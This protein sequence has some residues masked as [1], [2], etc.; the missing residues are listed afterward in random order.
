MY[1]EIIIIKQLSC[2]PLSFKAVSYVILLVSFLNVDFRRVAWSLIIF[3]LLD[4]L[5]TLRIFK[6]TVFCSVSQDYPWPIHSQP[7]HSYMWLAG[8]HTGMYIH[9]MKKIVLDILHNSSGFPVSRDGL[10][11]ANTSV[12]KISSKKQGLQLWSVFQLFQ[13]SFI[14]FH[15]L[16]KWSVINPLQPTYNGIIPYHV[17]LSVIYEYCMTGFDHWNLEQA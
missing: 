2:A 4:F 13:E 15:F 17:P 7:I 14:H 1:L 3:Q 6:S 9:K 8:K 11:P 10:I 16:I 12:V 5:V